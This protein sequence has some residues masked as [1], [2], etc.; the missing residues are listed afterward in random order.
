MEFSRQE[1]WSE[2][3]FSSPADPGIEPGSPTWQAD[4]L[5]TE[6]PG[7][8]YIYI[9]IK[10]LGFEAQFIYLCFG[11]AAWLTRPYFP[12]QGLDLGPLQWKFREL[13]TGPQEVPQ[14]YS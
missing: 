5:L 9:Y 12:D 10:E 3:P 8:R 11:H 13:T 7:K 2:L 4:S 1:T 14:L 6:P